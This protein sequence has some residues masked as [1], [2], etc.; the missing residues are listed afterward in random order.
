MALSLQDLGRKILS[1]ATETLGV[2]H[3]RNVLF[4]QAKVCQLDVAVATDE[5]VLWL[6]VAVQDVLAVEVLKCQQDVGCVEPS[7]V[8]LEATNLGEVEKE[9]ATGAVLKT[10][11][12]FVLRLESVVHLHN[13][14]VIHTLLNTGWRH[15][16]YLQN[17]RECGVQPSCARTSCAL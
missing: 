8:L 3:S 11:E 5:H 12:Q 16:N 1:S 10:E 15:K 2:L 6:Q 14:G 17:L 13:E 7:C 9:L 4:A